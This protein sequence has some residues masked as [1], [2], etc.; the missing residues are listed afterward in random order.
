MLAEV[1]HTAPA[2]RAAMA[3]ATA[4]WSATTT[5][6]AKAETASATPGSIASA[7]GMTKLSQKNSSAGGP[8]VGRGWSRSARIRASNASW[9]TGK[10]RAPEGS[11]GPS[12]AGWPAQAT[13]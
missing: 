2:R 13:S 11:N 6:G 10:T 5:S 7:S 1:A 8:R 3:P 12:M 9:V 4:C